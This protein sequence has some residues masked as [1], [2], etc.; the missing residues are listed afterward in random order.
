MAS[1]S[2]DTGGH[3]AKVVERSDGAE[4][5]GGRQKALGSSLRGAVSRLRVF[6]AV[7]LSA[8]ALGGLPWGVAVKG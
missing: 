8:V 5:S 1:G 6:A 2:P 4:A 3:E 7:A